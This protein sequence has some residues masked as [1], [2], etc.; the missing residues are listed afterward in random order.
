MIPSPP[1]PSTPIIHRP[2]I[3]CVD[4]ILSADEQVAICEYEVREGPHVRDGVMW[5]QGL[6]EGLA[7]SVSAL[8]LPPGAPTPGEDVIGMLVG[9]R[10]FAVHRRPRVGERIEWRVELIRRLGPFTLARGIA[11]SGEE[12]LAEGELKFYWEGI[13]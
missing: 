8:D 1:D 12:V 9:I 3:L 11:S 2:P 13:T 7:Q 6:V 5:E 4:A 10:G